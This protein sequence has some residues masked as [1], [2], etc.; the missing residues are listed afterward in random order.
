MRRP[1]ADS[2]TRQKLL[3]AAQE[4]M[5][6]KGYTATSVEEICATAGLT[7]GS[8]FHYFDGK[9]QLGK[10]AAQQFYASWQQQSRAAPFRRKKDPRDR[11][12]GQIDFFIE[13]SRLPAWKG[14]LL[15]TLVQELSATHPQ[16]RSVCAACLNDLAV[17]LQHDLEEAKAKYTPRARWSP[18]SLAEHLIAV[19]QGAI[20]LAKAKQDTRAFEESLGHFKEYLKRLFAM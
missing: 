3:D 19:A 6:A 10:L 16:I 7:K 1:Q 15:G 18:H 8:F 17:S 20:I 11:V 12:F 9:E 13:M 5:L 2:L 4:L 14:C